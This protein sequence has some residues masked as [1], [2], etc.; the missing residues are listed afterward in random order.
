MRPRG[1]P[2]PEVSELFRPMDPARQAEV[3]RQNG[4]N[5]QNGRPDAQRPPAGNQPEQRTAMVRAQEPR[6]PAP[7]RPATGPAGGSGPEATRKVDAAGPK[8]GQPGPAQNGG[9]GA[10]GQNGHGPAGNGQNGNHNGQNGNGQNG[11]GQ[12]GNGQ[13]GQNGNGRPPR[14]PEATVLTSAKPAD[15]QNDGNP[16][17]RSPS[18]SRK[19]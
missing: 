15:G 16:A 12:S 5:A 8:P 4:Q 2:E 7:A 14:S 9:R 10:P 13:N 11:N 17:G 6:G 18:G 3:A 19:G 1:A